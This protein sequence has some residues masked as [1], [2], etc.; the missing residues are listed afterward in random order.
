M[1]NE[2]LVFKK[3]IDLAKSKRLGICID[4]ISNL[5][6]KH[7]LEKMIDTKIIK[8]NMFTVKEKLP[9]WLSE[10]KNIRMMLDFYMTAKFVYDLYKRTSEINK[11]SNEFI[12]QKNDLESHKDNLERLIKKIDG[13]LKGFENFNYSSDNAMQALYEINTNISDIRSQLEDLVKKL[14]KIQIT[15]NN[16]IVKLEALKNASEVDDFFAS[17]I[18]VY[19]GG[20]IIYNL[21]NKNYFDALID[22]FLA[23]VN[24]S[25]KYV[26]S[27]NVETCNKLIKELV[28]S[29]NLCN[30][31]KASGESKL[32]ILKDKHELLNEKSKNLEL[33]IENKRLKENIGKLESENKR[34][35]RA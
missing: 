9:V 17:A 14:G 32:D 10:T 13:I 34:L 20:R 24:A 6:D 29:L 2:L 8:K 4:L 3:G 18:L 30:E 5:M 7:G 25:G 22:A 21:A 35:K 11:I 16:K 33:N 1:F 23:L 28:E 27:K 19:F 12:V 15:L 31:L 26:I